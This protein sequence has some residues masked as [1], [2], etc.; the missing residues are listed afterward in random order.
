MQ[1]SHPFVFSDAAVQN[2]NGKSVLL[3]CRIWYIFYE[4]KK[5]YNALFHVVLWVRVSVCPV[6]CSESM[7][8]QVADWTG[9]GYEAVS[10]A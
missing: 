7:Y 9:V 8:L 5:C 2:E 1:L 3:V 4:D 6:I 10:L